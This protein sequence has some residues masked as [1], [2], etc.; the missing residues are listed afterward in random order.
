MILIVDGKKVEVQNDV[1]V[2]YEDVTCMYED[3]DE[4][5][6]GVLQV[7]LTDEGAILDLFDEPGEICLRTAGMLIEDMERM[8]H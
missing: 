3:D 7:T 5:Y 6:R 1:K 8:C 4:E 2:V